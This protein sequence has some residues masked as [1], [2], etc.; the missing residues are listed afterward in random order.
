M[1]PRAPDWIYMKCHTF[2][3]KSQSK[4][5]FHSTRLFE[6]RAQNP[7]FYSQIV[8]VGAGEATPAEK[9]QLDYGGMSQLVGGLRGY[10]A[11]KVSMEARG[12]VVGNSGKT[13]S[14][15]SVGGAIDSGFA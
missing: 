7:S 15:A 8:S 14:E 4:N 9:L 12:T 11:S 3:M 13:Q 6:G 10:S 5:N 1:S 2:P